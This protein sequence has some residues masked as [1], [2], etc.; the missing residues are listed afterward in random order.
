MTVKITH[1]CETIVQWCI[2]V[3]FFQ[4]NHGFYSGP[5]AEQKT[6]RIEKYI[7]DRSLFPNLAVEEVPN[8]ELD[9][10]HFDEPLSN[11]TSS[12][13]KLG[14]GESL[15]AR[16]NKRLKRFFHIFVHYFQMNHFRRLSLNS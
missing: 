2:S 5:I 1:G 4:Y 9:H 14:K 15:R 13:A 8:Y 12:T 7:W 3:A 11:H 6:K 16:C 10:S